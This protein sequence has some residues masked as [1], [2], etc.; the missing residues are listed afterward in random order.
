MMEPLE[1][2]GRDD[3]K[4]MDTP[5]GASGSSDIQEVARQMI[6][7]TQ[8]EAR[9]TLGEGSVTWLGCFM[10]NQALPNLGILCKY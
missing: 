2:L 3:P 10:E 7:G 4:S 8:S 6:H 1:I 9:G 5:L